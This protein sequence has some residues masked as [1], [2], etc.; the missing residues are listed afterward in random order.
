MLRVMLR[1]MLRQ[2]LRLIL[3]WLLRLV[4][5][6]VLREMP[7]LVPTVLLRQVPT[8]FAN[9]GAKRMPTTVPTVLLTLLRT[10]HDQTTTANHPRRA[11]AIRSGRATK[12]DEANAVETLFADRH[13]PRSSGLQKVRGQ[14]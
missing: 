11:V 7:T 2:V 3:R 14:N 10:V 5:T 6:D 4:P 13:H 8:T 1:E 9:R 12:G